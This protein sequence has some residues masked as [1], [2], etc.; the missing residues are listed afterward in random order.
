MLN[1][2]NLND[3]YNLT[4]NFPKVA[5]LERYI[6][7]IA[8]DKTDGKYQGGFWDSELI[9]DKE[10]GVEFWFLKLNTD[11][12]FLFRNENKMCNEEVSSKLFSLLCFTFGV[13]TFIA[14]YYEDTS[15]ANIVEELYNLYHLIIANANLVLDEQELNIFYSIID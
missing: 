2:N 7:A 14:A 5:I 15:I 12:K 4:V 13:N 10:N 9:K 11:N 3:L 1:T 6:Y 8:R